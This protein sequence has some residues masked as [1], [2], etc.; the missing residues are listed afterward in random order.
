MAVLPED[1]GSIPSNHI[2]VYSCIIPVLGDLAS[3]H[4]QSYRQQTDAH[5]NLSFSLS[6]MCVCA[7]ACVCQVK[8]LAMAH[9]QR[10]E[11]QLLG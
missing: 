3:S 8:E 5:K 10:S 2:V 4:R 1:L 6:L 7:R 9:T 11:D